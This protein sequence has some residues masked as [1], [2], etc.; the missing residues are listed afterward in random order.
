[1]KDNEG[2]KYMV[3]TPCRNVANASQHCKSGS[4]FPQLVPS[5]AYQFYKTNEC[6]ALGNLSFVSAAGDANGVY[7]RYA[8]G[9]DE[10]SCPMGRAVTYNILC[11]PNATVT[12]GPTNI[13]N[14]VMCE[15]EV[16]WPSPAGCPTYQPYCGEPPPIPTPTP[17]QLGYALHEIIA[18][19]HFNMATFFQDGDPGCTSGNWNGPGG[20]SDPASFAPTSLNFTSWMESFVA[21]GAQH[22]VL[23]AKHGCGHLLWPSRVTLPNGTVYPYAVGRPNSYIQGDVLA[24]F[25]AACNTVG[26]GHGFYYSLTNNFFL[27]VYGHQVQPGPIL[28]GQVNVTQAEFQ[29]IAIGHLT[30]LWS[31]YGELTE[32]WFD[33]GYSTDM[34]PVIENMLYKLQPN[35]AAFQGYGVSP[36]PIRW[37]GTESGITNE[38]I[39]STGTAWGSGDPNSPLWCPATCDTTLQEGDHWFWE[40]NTPI[41]NLTEL[42]EVYHDTVGNN[43]VLELDFAIDRTG[44]VD[45]VH[46]VMYASFGNWIRQCY[47]SPIASVSGRTTWIILPLPGH[48]IVDRVVIREDQSFG[49]RIRSYEVSYDPGNGVWEPFSTGTSVGNKRIDLLSSP[50]T[51]AYLQLKVTNSTAQPVISFFGAFAPCP[52]S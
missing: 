9:Q 11:D 16:Y 19:I 12:A 26:I 46:A 42:I 39:W 49:Q 41:R 48:F 27:N 34:Q 51:V 18:L 50:V 36:N 10:P 33:G 21:L 29:A 20:S 30:E 2:Y 35:A 23:T 7:I 37:I 47:G 25:V 43:G 45:P 28:P 4:P 17:T 31:D 5:P 52:S 1:M 3:T 15:Y 40:P 13:T 8:G 22:A 6:I 44:N 24:G 14:D 38:A 32:I